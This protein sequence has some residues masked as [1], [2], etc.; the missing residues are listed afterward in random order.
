MKCGSMLNDVFFVAQSI[1]LTGRRT[2]G[3]SRAGNRGPARKATT[4]HRWRQE[5]GGVKEETRRC[6]G[7]LLLGFRN[8][9]RDFVRDVRLQLQRFSPEL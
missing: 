2:P 8:L 3:I 7:L 6:G 4:Y 1:E 9:L 5:Y